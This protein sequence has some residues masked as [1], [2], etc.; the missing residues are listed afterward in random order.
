MLTKYVYRLALFCLLATPIVIPFFWLPLTDDPWGFNKLVLFYCLTAVALIAWLIYSITTK[1]VRLTLSEPLLPLLLLAI[2]AIAAAIINQTADPKVWLTQTGI[3]L[4]GW[5]YFLLTTTL[6]QT[7]PAIKQTLAGIIISVSLIAF[8]GI[9]DNFELNFLLPA[10]TTPVGSLLN[11]IS[12]LLAWIPASLT[13]AIKSGSGPKK[14]GYFLLSG[15]IASSLIL[16]GANLFTQNSRKPVLLPLLYGWSISIDT[17]KNQLFFGTGPGQFGHSFTR[18]KPIGLNLAPSW[19][20]YFSVNSNWYLEI[21]TTLGLVGFI[22]LIWTILTVIK[23]CRR[24]PGTRISSNQLALIISLITQLLTGLLIPFTPLNLIMFLATVS[25]LTITYKFKQ[26]TQLKDILL[27]LNTAAVVDPWSTPFPESK[28]IQNGR[29]LA[30]L[31]SLPL[32]LGL[33]I[34][35]FY[36]TKVYRAEYYFDKSLKAAA[37]NQGKQTYDLQVKAIA[38]L[39]KSDRLRLHYSNTN[40]AL[41]N[42][43]AAKTNLSDQEKQTVTTLIQQ[44]VREARIA[45]QL[46]PNKAGNWAHLAKIYNNLVN[47]AQGADQFAKAA[48]IKAIQLDPANPALRLELGGLFYTQREFEPAVDRFKE[49]ITLK[50][51]YANAY[52]N[53]SYAYQSQGKWMEA[54]Q[55]MEM[56]ASLVPADSADA[57]KARNELRLLEEKLQQVKTEPTPENSD[58]LQP[59]ATPL[60]APTGFT[61]INL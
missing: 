23:L 55:A 14:I 22:A 53:L 42:A 1:T 49:A 12:L 3:Y 44:A 4:A 45:T 61:P 34:A 58:L 46:N 47:F 56:A 9:L 27:S 30:W 7:A 8:W 54:Y 25:L 32:I 39:P 19:N 5:I 59:P 41:A 51:N 35:F 28:P 13:L 57:I 33:A 60:P 20:I 10:G 50:N 29:L 40:L 31:L 17:L 36:L 38:Q 21:L 52:Y 26:I 43:L 15:L 16:N 37:A 6:V 2:T 18:F 48:Y 24:Q 11:L